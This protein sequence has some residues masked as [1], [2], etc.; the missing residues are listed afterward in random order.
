MKVMLAKLRAPDEPMKGAAA[1]A[2]A[3]ISN[4]PETVDA[5]LRVAE[6]EG[7]AASAR[8]AA[9]SAAGLFRRTDPKLQMSG[10]RLD[11]L[12]KRLL[13]LAGSAKAS[14]RVRCLAV[15]SVGMLGDQPYG[16][17]FPAGLV[18]NRA[19]SLL[20]LEGDQG[21]EMTVALLTA[22]GLQPT[23]G[24][25]DVVHDTLHDVVIGRRAAGRRWNEWERSHALSTLMRFGRPSARQLMLRVLTD[26]R[27]TPVAVR[28][29]AFIALGACARE[30]TPVERLKIFRSWD[31]GQRL[32]RDPLTQGLASIALGRLVAADVRVTGGR[33][34]ESADAGDRLLQTVRRSPTAT[35]GFAVIALALAA[36]AARQHEERSTRRFHEAAV[37]QILEGLERAKGDGIARG[38]FAVAAGL[39]DLEEALPR[40]ERLVQDANENAELR[41]FAAV[42]CG[43]I[44]NPT[45]RTVRV[46]Q[47]A[48]RDR[49]SGP[50]RR[51]AALALAYLS[52]P[53]GATALRQRMAD[54]RRHHTHVLG[55]VA[56]ALGQMGD[57]DSVGVLS[58][59]LLDDKARHGARGAS[60][61]A[62]GLLCDPEERP[63]LSRLWEDVNY[64]ARTVSLHE[65]LNYF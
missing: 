23:E 18:T 47:V 56:L 11:T 59:T 43:Q 7:M 41:G 9:T 55:H 45:R 62:L 17:A 2:L 27:R 48:L 15:L 1:L 16:G 44:G 53:E 3:R 6:A 61:V 54:G 51:E 29:A 31:A 36:R 12:R 52:G 46:I 58:E 22:L 10:E 28:R 8:R 4:Q 39:M 49:R 21:T 64:P 25:G 5:V 37:A 13:A 42:A 33:L 57:L 63:S 60:A 26:K 38:A 34:V 40:L 19:L 50:M 20:L 30:L 65:V 24:M 14:L 35:R 32:A